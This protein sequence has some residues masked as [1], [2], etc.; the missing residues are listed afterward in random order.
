MNYLFFEGNG[1]PLYAGKTYQL[2]SSVDS[3][4]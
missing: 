1:Y 3:N 4:I 2:G